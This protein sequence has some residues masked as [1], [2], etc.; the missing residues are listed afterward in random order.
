MKKIVETVEIEQL[1]PDEL[2]EAERELV[3]LAS[4]ATYRSYA[5]YSRFS[6]GAAVRL[7]NGETVVGTNQENAAFPSGMCAE[8]TAA[9]A[10]HSAFPDARFVAV[11]I[12]ARD[13]DGMLTAAPVSPCGACRQVL[14]EY[15]NLFGTAVT[16]LL[17]GRDAIYRIPSVRSLLPI[18]FAE[19]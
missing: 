5:P 13:G 8:R 6:V 10:A 14:L 12:A 7:S 18:A 4:E 9:Y 11:C 3:S 2:T 1:A 19:F 15:E 17:V 16:I